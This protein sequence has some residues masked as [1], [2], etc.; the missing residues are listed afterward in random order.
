MGFGSLA[1]PSAACEQMLDQDKVE[2][3]LHSVQTH[4]EGIVREGLH[5]MRKNELWKRMLYGSSNTGPDSR[6]AVLVD[7]SYHDF[8]DLLYMV[9][10]YPLEVLDPRLTPLKKQPRKW[11]KKLIEP[12]KMRFA[13][14]VHIYCSDNGSHT[15]AAIVN[16][17]WQ[18]MFVLVHCDSETHRQGLSAVYRKAEEG[19]GVPDKER[20]ITAHLEA[21]RQHIETVVNFC[22][23]FMWA[24][25]LDAAPPP[26]TLH[27]L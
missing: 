8:R 13:E 9:T 17:D 7:L 27:L 12:L 1:T 23:S 20:L 21:D 19:G 14:N 25:I 2:Q 3:Q 18:D 15:Y 4:L 6:P 10:E 24:T 26:P 22:C 5:H 16:P 11:F